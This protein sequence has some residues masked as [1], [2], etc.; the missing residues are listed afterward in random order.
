M[1]NKG[2]HDDC[3]RPARL[4]GLPG[5]DNRGAAGVLVSGPVTTSGLDAHAIL[6][7]S[8]GGGGG[9]AV[10]GQNNLARGGSGRAG[11]ASGDGGVVKVQLQPGARIST[12]GAG[13]YGILAQSI[14][15]GGGAAGDFSAP[16][17]YQLGTT[18][19]VMANSGSG[20]AVSIARRFAVAP[21]G[22]TWRSS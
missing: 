11:G 14:G 20:G 7:Q 8:I 15:G 4:L 12:S 22:R 2:L 10:G 19:A 17:H 16:N 3:E 9:M 18:G 21:N 1:L 5:S 13:A 6:A